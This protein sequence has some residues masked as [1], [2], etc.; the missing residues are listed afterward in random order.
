M[1]QQSANI[2][3]MDAY[4][5]YQ[6]TKTAEIKKMCERA[7]TSFGNFQQIAIARGSCSAK[8]ARR[9]A[10]ASRRKMTEMELLY[11]DYSKGRERK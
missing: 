7:E 4:D 9:L 6:K 11:P 2:C 5:Y 10:T 8:M 1:R 3:T